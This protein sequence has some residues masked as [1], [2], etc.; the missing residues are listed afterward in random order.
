MSS[1]TYDQRSEIRLA[2][3][4]AFVA[5]ERRRSMRVKH[6]TSAEIREWKR[7]KEGLPFTACIE[8]FAPAGVGVLHGTELTVGSQYLIKIPREQ[9]GDLT[10]LMTVVRCKQAND[11]QFHIGMEISSVMD[12]TELGKFVDALARQTYP[13][14]WLKVAFL[15]F[16]ICGIAATLMIN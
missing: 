16:G 2:F 8:D 5:P 9:F 6:I 12:Q 15:L 4:E 11:G 14:R 1:L 7:G 3:D 13:P 10:V